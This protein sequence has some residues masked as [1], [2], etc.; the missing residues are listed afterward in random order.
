MVLTWLDGYIKI[1]R[2]RLSLHYSLTLTDAPLFAS[3]S[4][5]CSGR[6]MMM[7]ERLVNCRSQPV[8][9]GGKDDDEQSIRGEMG[10]R[11]V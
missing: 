1:P 10:S 7:A 3:G 8:G 4:S 2:G 5:G 11:M 6:E 9:G